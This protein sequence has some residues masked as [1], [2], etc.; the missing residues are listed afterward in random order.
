MRRRQARHATGETACTSAAP[1]TSDVTRFSLVIFL[2][3]DTHPCPR[4]SDCRSRRTDDSPDVDQDADAELA[5]LMNS[6]LDDFEKQKSVPRSS[7]NAPVVLTP[8][9]RSQGDSESIRS[10]SE[11]EQPPFDP[12]MM[13]E[14]DDI[15]KNMMSQDPMLK[16]HW[17]RLT[18]SCSRA[19]KSRDSSPCLIPYFH[20]SAENGSEE[21]FEKSL[22]D[23]LKKMSDNMQS[24]PKNADIPEEEMAKIW[25][26][27]GMN[28][29]SAAANGSGI[30]PDIMPLVTNMMQNLLSKDILY[31]ALKEL[32]EKYPLWL[33]QNSSSLSDEDLERFEKQLG[34]MK[35]VVSEFEAESPSD[36]DDTKKTRFQKILTTMQQ[37]QECGAP[38]KDLVGEVP[39]MG[40]PEFDLSKIPGLNPASGTQCSIQ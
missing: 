13:R 14:V 27:L 28:G 30:L 10:D 11:Q 2:L 25:S 21:D 8:D 5:A 16:E 31:P 22:Q 35:Q 39:D 19:G 37:M 26:N 7:R 17:E 6:A 33:D 29:E 20:P 1:L 38:P 23:T 40:S 3:H 4:M 32:T 15:F 36:S 18:D 34:L 9:T 24:L 12:E